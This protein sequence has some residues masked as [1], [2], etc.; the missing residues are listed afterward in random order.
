[1]EYYCNGSI[2]KVVRDGGH[3]F[4]K[5]EKINLCCQVSAGLWHLHA[6]H[7]VHADLALR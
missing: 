5:E 7:V 3:I 6:E 1:M 4:T 2:L